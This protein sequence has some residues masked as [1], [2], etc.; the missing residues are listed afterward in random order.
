MEKKRILYL[1]N[2]I[3]NLHAFKA[4]FRLKANY[5]IYIYQN[6]SDCFELLK[7][8]K[9]HIVVLNQSKQEGN[10]TELIERIGKVDPDVLRIVVT[11]YC[12][13]SIVDKVLNDGKIYSYHTKP[14]D[15]NEIERSIESAFKLYSKY[16]NGDNSGN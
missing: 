12:D 13:T 15:L 3:Y 10:I 1:D 14:W 9:I 4:H 11:G 2:E 5:E 6:E 7:K 8:E 16:K